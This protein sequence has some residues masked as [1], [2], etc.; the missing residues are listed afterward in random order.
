MASGKIEN[1]DQLLLNLGTQI[2]LTTGKDLFIKDQIEK[3]AEDQ[4]LL[5]RQ[6]IAQQIVL[7]TCIELKPKLNRQVYNDMLTIMA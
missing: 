6:A 4:R 3:Q 2:D 7:Q 5:Q 1:I